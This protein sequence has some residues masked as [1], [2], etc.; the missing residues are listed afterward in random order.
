MRKI[1][2][3]FCFFNEL[4]IL[5]LRLNILDPYVDYYVLSEASVTHNGKPKSFYFEENKER[6]A[7]FLHKIIHLKVTDTPEQFI[8]LPVNEN[9]ITFDQKCLND[10]WGFI[11]LTKTFNRDNEQH[12]GRDFFQKESIRRGLENCADEDIIISSDLDEI[13]NPDVLAR[14]DSFF[15]HNQFYMFRQDTYYYY[16][17]MLKEKEWYGSRMGTYGRL[18]HYSYNELR[19]DKQTIIQDGG[20]HFSFQGGK[21]SVKKKIESYCHIDLNTD[22]IK[23][24]IADNMEKGVDPFFRGKLTKVPV[25]NTFPKYLLDNLDKY[26]HLIKQ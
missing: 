25:D 5:E 14:L 11:P 15:D 3:C 21:E 1:Y 6:F 20:W 17:N 10:I 4:D 8:V 16:L 26:Q 24:S 18:K 13:P 9:P 12:Y 7:P 22:E 2:D 23:N 19:K